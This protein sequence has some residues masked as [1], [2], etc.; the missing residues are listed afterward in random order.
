MW[1]VIER[2]KIFFLR[3]KVAKQRIVIHGD[4]K[5]ALGTK[6]CC[7]NLNKLKP[8]SQQIIKLSSRK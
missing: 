4:L 1:F 6:K 5:K 8:I 3:L 7:L 2:K